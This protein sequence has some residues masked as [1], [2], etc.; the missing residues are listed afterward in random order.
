MGVGSWRCKG[1]KQGGSTHERWRITSPDIHQASFPLLN[2]IITRGFKYAVA[3]HGSSRS[4]ILV[5]GG[6][7]ATSL[8]SEI[9]RAIEGAVAGSGIR[10]N[11]A[12]S[13]T[14]YEGNSSRNVVS[15]LTVAERTVSRSSIAS[16]PVKVTGSPSLMLWPTSTTPSHSKTLH[17]VVLHK[18]GG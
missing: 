9:K 3:F 16:R 13:D 7:A 5:G 8:K 2:K 15:R 18:D 14:G 6:T 1:W 17:V 11:I 4:D 10:V 12:P